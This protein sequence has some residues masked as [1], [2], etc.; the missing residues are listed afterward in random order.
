MTRYVSAFIGGGSNIRPHAN[1]PASLIMLTRDV[2]V[3][4]TSRFYE[5]KP[6][7]QRDQ[8]DFINGV[9]HI[10]TSLSA[11]ELKYEVLRRIEHRLG[12]ERTGD[13]YASRPIDLDVILYADSVSTSD[14]LQLP[15]PDIYTRPFLAV[16]LAELAPDYVLPDSGRIVSAVAGEYEN[17]NMRADE[18]LNANLIDIVRPASA[19]CHIFRL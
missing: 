7:R 17:H 19:V 3:L 6:L 16:P 5:T 11:R 12:R 18:E 10:R 9:W 4:A 13:R 8:S 1:I 15:D 2:E 14:D